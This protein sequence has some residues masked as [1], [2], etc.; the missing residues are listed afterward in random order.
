[1]VLWSSFFHI[2]AA[3]FGWVSYVKTYT[4]PFANQIFVFV[5]AAAL[6]YIAL[7]NILQ[8]LYLLDDDDSSLQDRR[9]T[10]YASMLLAFVTYFL[11]TSIH[12]L[13]KDSLFT[14]QIRKI[15]R[16]YNLGI[17]CCIVTAISYIPGI[18][19]SD[20]NDSNAGGGID[21]VQT[22]LQSSYSLT[23]TAVPPLEYIEGKGI[24]L[25]I[26]PGFLLFVL[27]IV[28]HTMCVTNIYQKLQKRTNDNQLD[29]NN[30]T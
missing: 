20:N 24:I 4:T 28:S 25:A 3:I 10:G 22:L 5:I 30:N 21:R 18:D 13:C 15:L 19:Q 7:Q 27:S 9:S 6:L 14:I 16:M 1:M 26:F 12:K 29:D 8:P 23:I 2:L 17:V 11:Y